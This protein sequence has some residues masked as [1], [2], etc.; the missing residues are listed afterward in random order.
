MPVQVAMA[1]QMASEDLIGVPIP[2]HA[3]RTSRF[4]PPSIIARSESYILLLMAVVGGG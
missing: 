2:D 4:Y 3:S 1:S